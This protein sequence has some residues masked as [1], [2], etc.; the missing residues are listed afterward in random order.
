MVY[1]S[2]D[3]SFGCHKALYRDFCRKERNI[4]IFMRDWWL[5]CTVGFDNWGVGLVFNDKRIV[6]SMPFIK[7]VDLFLTFPMPHLTPF[8]GPW[9]ASGKTKYSEK[10]GQQ[11]EI[12][13]ELIRQL[14][15]TD[16]FYRIGITSILTGSL[17][18]GQRLPT[19]NKLYLRY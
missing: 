4:P 3:K 6:A 13:A 19:D 15:Q 8:L 1:S 17:F 7:K 12:M 16:F 10:L 9:I 5:D 11:K 2:C 14:P 18:I